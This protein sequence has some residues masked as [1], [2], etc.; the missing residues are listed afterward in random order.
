MSAI[1]TPMIHTTSAN[2]N[3]SEMVNIELCRGIS[4]VDVVPPTGVNQQDRYSIIFH[5]GDSSTGNPATIKWSYA[6]E[7]TRDADYVL[8][9]AAASAAI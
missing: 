2:V 4:K 3:P 9:L 7:A 5:I 8:V 1:A 6:L